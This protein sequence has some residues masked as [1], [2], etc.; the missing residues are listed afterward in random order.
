MYINDIV[1]ARTLPSQKL[2]RQRQRSVP[3]RVGTDVMKMAEQRT[4]DIHPT[5]ATMATG[6]ARQNKFKEPTKN[7]AY[8]AKVNDTYK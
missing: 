7:L 4:R 8:V 1:K 6:K 2:A 5:G 3:L